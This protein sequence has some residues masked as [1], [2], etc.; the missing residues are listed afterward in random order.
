MELRAIM[1]PDAPKVRAAAERV[2]ALSAQIGAEKKRLVD[3]KGEGDIAGSLAE[4]EAA[5]VEKEFAEA[6]YR[7][8]L[9]TLEVARAE[10]ARQH[11]YLAVVSSPSQPDES[12]HPRRALGVLTVFLMSF[13]A[14][15]IVSLL[16]ASVREH[17]RV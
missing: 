8:A 14:L 11:R 1:T 3:P 17:A 15:G 9:A 6:S 12:T 16:V 4:F 13:L 2:K 5:M 10:A 7:S